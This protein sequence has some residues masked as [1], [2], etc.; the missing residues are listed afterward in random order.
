MNEI[1]SNPPPL[2]LEE[3]I[4]FIKQIAKG[5]EGTIHLAKWRGQ[6]IVVKKPLKANSISLSRELHVF[7]TVIHPCVLNLLEQSPNLGWF[8]LPYMEK[9]ALSSVLLSAKEP[10]PWSQRIQLSCDIAEGLQFLHKAG[11]LHCDIKAD[12]ILIDG[13]YRGKLADFG[14]VQIKEHP[15]WQFPWGG[16]VTYWSPELIPWMQRL[17]PSELFMYF[18]EANRV[19]VEGKLPLL[20][21]KATS[22]R[23]ELSF[24]R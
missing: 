19:K 20:V 15:E 10:F 21:K 9:G 2:P 1:N 22:M 6:T 12:N 17:P 3:E 8:L 23:S 7:K 14:I 4:Q 5:G 24:G 11:I 13:K 16:S 18:P